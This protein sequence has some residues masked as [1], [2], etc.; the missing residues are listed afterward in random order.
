MQF[1]KSMVLVVILALSISLR[2]DRIKQDSL[3]VVHPDQVFQGMEVGHY[4][5]FGF[6]GL[7]SLAFHSFFFFQVRE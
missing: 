6:G 2:F 1:G 3:N 5:Y 7:Y 4:F